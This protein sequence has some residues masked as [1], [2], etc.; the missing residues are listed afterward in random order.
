MIQLSHSRRCH[1][2]DNGKLGYCYRMG[3]YQ[4]PLELSQSYVCKARRRTHLERGA[5]NHGGGVSPCLLTLFAKIADIKGKGTFI[6]NHTW[7]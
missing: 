2:G 3:V 7:V 4:K 5:N 1:F 6:G